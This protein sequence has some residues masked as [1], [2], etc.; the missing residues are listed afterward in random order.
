MNII[1]KYDKPFEY[2]G[3]FLNLIIAY[4]FY[5]LWSQPERIGSDKIYSYVILIVFE[6]IMV[7]SGA[8]M[9]LMPRKIS[10]YA[11]VPTYSLFAIIFSTIEASGIIMITY[12][13]VVFNRMRF[14]F[15]N[16]SVELKLRVIMTSLYA[17]MTYFILTFT[18]VLGQFFISPMGLT[19]EYLEHSDYFNNLTATGLFVEAPHLAIAFGCIYYCTL[20]VIELHLLHSN[21][22]KFKHLFNLNE[23]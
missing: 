19:Q 22:M 13:I 14:A 5:M 9:S 20:A 8:L 23:R 3:I 2:A 15:A 21:S 4:Q 12:L 11:L 1:E 10:L 7:H 18:V 16:V 6:F 17:L